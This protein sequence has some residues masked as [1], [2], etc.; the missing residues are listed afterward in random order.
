[1]KKKTKVGGVDKF[2]PNLHRFSHPAMATIYEI[3]I[4]HKDAEYAA[5]AA[6]AAFAE[7]DRL[8]R[9]LSRFISNSDISRINLL[10]KSDAMQV[11]PDA[12]E[13]LRQCK[14]LF[15]ETNGAFD[16]TAGFLLNCWIN[17]DK[18]PRQPSKKEI[19]DVLSRMGMNYIHLD[20][21]TFTVQVMNDGVQ[22]D[23]G[24]FG[25][26]YALDQVALLLADWEIENALIHGGRSS[27]LAIGTH[28]QADGW[29]I[30]LSHPANPEK[31]LE[32]L[33]LKNRTLSGS[34]L[35]K[36]QHIID[37][38]SGYPVAGKTAAW[39]ASPDGAASDALS[40]AFMIMSPEEIATYCSTHP[41]TAGKLITKKIKG[42][43]GGE[44]ILTVGSW[45]NIYTTNE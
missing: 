4:Y 34:G 15:E 30:T 35:Q 36:G 8:E 29:P 42:N 23:L 25:K 1:M 2:K 24:G 7:I 21:T 13:C 20:E 14:K 45:E 5:Q 43:E 39:A 3:I 10:S 31:V 18:S 33:L 26:G 22:I 9:E 38:R 27:V 19:Q 37:P 44:E 41:N 16:I 12:F 32:T 40:T 11:G 28:P 6:H 17:K